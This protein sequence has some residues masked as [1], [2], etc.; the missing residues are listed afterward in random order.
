[1]TSALR[2]ARTLLQCRCSLLLL[3]LVLLLLLLVLLLLLLVLLL[4]LLRRRRR[5]L[6]CWRFH[7]CRRARWL[8]LYGRL[9]QAGPS[10][11]VAARRRRRRSR[12]RGA[13][14]LLLDGL[15]P[16][17]GAG[18]AGAKP[19]R[20]RSPRGCPA[21]TDGGLLPPI[22]C[23]HRV[24]ATGLV[25]WQRRNR[26]PWALLTP[27][28]TARLLRRR[29]ASWGE[30]DVCSQRAVLCTRAMWGPVLPHKLLR[31]D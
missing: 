9:P 4:L 16:K 5:L 10:S 18:C 26:T 31:S 19:W 23:V 21:R 2:V 20:R 28:F 8:L 22:V 3:L 30:E 17:I 14:P 29:R 13:G 27:A 25:L 7:G 24:G 12:G 15:S 6:Q 1:M 11:A